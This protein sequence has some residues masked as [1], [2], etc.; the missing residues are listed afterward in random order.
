MP[1]CSRE[2][3]FHVSFD[4]VDQVVREMDALRYV[5]EKRW[6]SVTNMQTFVR[7]PHPE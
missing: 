2:L 4:R 7:G 5:L 3:A 1:F 6:F